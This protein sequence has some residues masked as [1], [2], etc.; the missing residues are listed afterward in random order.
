MATGCYKARFLLFANARGGG[1]TLLSAKC[2]APGTH[3]VSNAR[4][5]LGGGMLAAG[6]DSHITFEQIGTVGQF[7]CIEL[8][9]F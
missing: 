4:G 1:G 8:F 6:T 3:L 5:L 2:Q 7:V 9:D